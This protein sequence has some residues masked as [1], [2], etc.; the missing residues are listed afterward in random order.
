MGKFEDG[1]TVYDL[2]DDEGE[3]AV[4]LAGEIPMEVLKRWRAKREGA[5]QSQQSQSEPGGSGDGDLDGRSGGTRP[6]T[7][8]DLHDVE[9]ELM[10]LVQD[11]SEHWS[12]R[13]TQTP[14]EKAV[15]DALATPFDWGDEDHALVIQGGVMAHVTGNH[16]N[17]MKSKLSKIL[18][19]LP[20][21]VAE[22]YDA[23]DLVEGYSSFLKFSTVCVE[24]DKAKAHDVDKEWYDEYSEESTS[25]TNFSKLFQN[26]QIRIASEA[27]AE[28]VGSIMT[29]YCGKGRYLEPVNFSKEICLEFNL[30]PVFL[31]DNMIEK[32][33]NLRKREYIYK[34]NES[35]ALHLHFSHMADVDEESAVRTYR[36][37]QLDKAHLPVEI[38]KL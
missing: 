32:L 4:A 8:E 33:Y 21:S 10:S 1:Q 27:M 37:Q 3:A 31:L 9:E 17:A 6:F 34:T 22:R 25:H 2:F 36:K 18:A 15:Y 14:L 16:Y 24:I 13:I 28:T 26:L 5:S 12:E 19:H 7:E 35:G 23:D 20:E 29:N 11:I 30:G 38:W